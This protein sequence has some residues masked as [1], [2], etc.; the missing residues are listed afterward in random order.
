MRVWEAIY[1]TFL[2]NFSSGSTT[3]DSISTQIRDVLKQSQQLQDANA[4]SLLKLVRRLCEDDSKLNKTLLNTCLSCFTL[5]AN[6]GQNLSWRFSAIHWTVCISAEWQ[7]EPMAGQS[8]TNGYC[9]WLHHVSEANPTSPCWTTE[10]T[11]WSVILFE[12]R[13]LIRY[14]SWSHL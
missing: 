9:I 10:S 4:S 14:I 11:T 8:Q 2:T 13:R 6:F 12:K 5:H 3:G 1:R 7:L